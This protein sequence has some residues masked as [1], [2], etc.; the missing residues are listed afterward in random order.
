MARID[1]R[2][3]KDGTLTYRIKVYRGRDP[4]TGKQLTPYTMTWESPTTWSEKKADKEAEKQAALFEDKCKNNQIST[5]KKTFFVYAE[6]VIDLKESQKII[7]HNTVVE[8]RRMNKNLKNMIGYSKIPEITTDVLNAL[9]VKLSKTNFNKSDKPLSPKSVLEYH[10]FVSSVLTYAVYEKIIPFNPAGTAKTPKQRKKEVNYFDADVALKILKCVKNEPI[11]WQLAVNLLF[12]TAGRRGEVLGL[13]WDKINWSESTYKIKEQVLYN[14]DTGVRVDATKEDDVRVGT[15]SAETIRLLKKYKS[16]QSE[17]QLRLGDRWEGTG[18][19]FT[20]W[21]GRPM[22]P[23]SLNTYLSRFSEKYGL[24]HLN[25]HA[26][27]HTSATLMFSSG[28]DVITT[29]KKL[30]H[31]KPSTTM[32]MYGHT[33][34]DAEKQAS[35]VLYNALKKNS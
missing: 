5:S 12:D 25:P 11:K 21:N 14:K 24:P 20:Q 19:I 3:R 32:D 7:K 28:V 16:N 34:R 9:Y 22:H 13:K 10:R 8:Y 6:Y 30:G 35:A 17:E 27:R 31:A 23:D 29:S 1:K 2:P 4:E 18:H 15:L 33:L 26:F